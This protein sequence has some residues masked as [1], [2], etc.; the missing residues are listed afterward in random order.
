MRYKKSQSI[1]SWV[2]V[3]GT[4]ATVILYMSPI[5]RRILIKRIKQI[6]NLAL[7]TE[8]GPTQW[9]ENIFN[10]QGSVVRRIR[11]QGIG[12]HYKEDEIESTERTDTYSRNI[13]HEHRGVISDYAQDEE[14]NRVPSQQVIN[15]ELHQES[16]GDGFEDWL[17]D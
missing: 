5:F 6:N 8:E 1:L 12:L 7:W 17:K 11:H 16:V 10:A 13:L 9:T 2:L 15:R 14:G 3:I 4:A